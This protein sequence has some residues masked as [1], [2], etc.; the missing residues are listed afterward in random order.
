MTDIFLRTFQGYRMALLLVGLG[1][2]ALTLLI[3]YTFEAFGGLEAAERLEELIPESMRALLKAQGGFGTTATGYLA[4]DYRHPLYIV[5][6]SAFVI[7]AAGGAVSREVERGT[8]LL[9]L[10]CPVPRWRFLTAKIGAMVGGLM[11]VLA[12]ALAGTWVGTLATGLTDQVDMSVILRVQLNGLALALA[13]GGY[14]VLI[15][16]LSSD[17]SRA[18]GLAAALTVAFFF[19]DF[20]AIL[21]GPAGPAGPASIF[22]YYDPLAIAQEGGIPWR[23]IGV[24]LGVGAAG[25][26]LAL[27]G[28]QRRDI[29]R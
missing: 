3:V 13:I 15:S 1:L 21:W 23:D 26:A 5:I 28:F 29:N 10:A 14:A 17:G 16:A 25:F 4:A 20:L 12:L 8:I 22:H 27:A 6:V 7:S 9:L 18:T 19:L 11:V 2:F 24:L